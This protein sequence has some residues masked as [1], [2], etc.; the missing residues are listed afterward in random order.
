MS[1]ATS[2]TSLGFCS[3]STIDSPLSFNLRM[4][5]ITSATICGARPSDGSSISSTR[6][7]PISARPIAS[8]CCSPPERCAAIWLR[9]SCNRGNIANTVSAVHGACLL[10][11]SGLRAAT[12]RFSRTVK[13]LKMRRPCGTNATPAAATS[14]GDRPVTDLPNTVT[15]PLRGGNRPTATFMQVDLPAP[16]RPSRPSIR[17]SLRLNETSASTWLSP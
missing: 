15:S 17:A 3:T 9:R 16:L 8:I 2:K 7:L 6:G 5:A 14:S 4:V 10:P 13:L 12:M 1:S 11:A